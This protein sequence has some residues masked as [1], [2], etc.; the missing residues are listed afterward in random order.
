MWHS[1]SVKERDVTVRVRQT[2][3]YMTHTKETVPQCGFASILLKVIS[4]N[5][6]SLKLNK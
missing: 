2:A 6:V 4:W 5:T 3:Q 1:K